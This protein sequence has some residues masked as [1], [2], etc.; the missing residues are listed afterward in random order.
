MRATRMICNNTSST[1]YPVRVHL[2]KF[3]TV[4][5]QLCIYYIISDLGRQFKATHVQTARVKSQALRRC[6]NFKLFRQILGCTIMKIRLARS[7]LSKQSFFYLFFCLYGWTNSQP[8][9][10]FSSSIRILITSN[11]GVPFDLKDENKLIF[12]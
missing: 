6:R 1:Y 12:I 3:H 5:L 4:N 8:K 11:C 9:S 2:V 10:S 7:S